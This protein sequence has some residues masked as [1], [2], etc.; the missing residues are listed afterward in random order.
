[1]IAAGP[2]RDARRSPLTSQEMLPGPPEPGVARR[3]VVDAGLVVTAADGLDL[4]AEP[5]AQVDACEGGPSSEHAGRVR[6]SS[7]VLVY[8]LMTHG[9]GGVVAPP[10]LAERFG[11]SIDPADPEAGSAD[12][13][14]V[15]ASFGEGLE[16]GVEQPLGA[17]LRRVFGS[18]SSSSPRST[19]GHVNR[20]PAPP[21]PLAPRSRRACRSGGSGRRR[22]TSRLVNQAEPRTG[23]RPRRRWS[24]A[25]RGAPAFPR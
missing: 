11:E 18:R 22:G 17:D 20:A 14:A 15:V 1:M 10:G 2:R 3:S 12:R 21:R 23:G 24:S 13:H 16:R 8:F 6:T 4:R 5:R 9:A 19:R 25:H 7:V